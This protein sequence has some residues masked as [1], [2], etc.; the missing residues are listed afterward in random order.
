[1]VEGASKEKA[2]WYC[3]AVL[4]A[5][6]DL[7]DRTVAAE[8]RN[9]LAFPKGNIRGREPLQLLGFREGKDSAVIK[10]CNGDAPFENIL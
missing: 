2:L 4:L 3:S 5:R 9:I 1:M 10:I 7:L 6:S 8:V